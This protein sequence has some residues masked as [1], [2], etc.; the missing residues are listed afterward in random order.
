MPLNPKGR[1]IRAAMRAE[2]GSERGDRIFYASER[3]G[4]IA[5]VTERKLHRSVPKRSKR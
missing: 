4:T 3:K 2:Y 1:K 5:G